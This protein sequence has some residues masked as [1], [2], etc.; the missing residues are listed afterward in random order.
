M[1]QGVSPEK[2]ESLWGALESN[3]VSRRPKHVNGD[4]RATLTVWPRE[5]LYIC[6]RAQ[7]VRTG[8]P[9][10]FRSFVELYIL[11]LAS[12]ARRV[13]LEALTW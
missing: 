11:S 1:E 3:G 13:R 7:V 4:K 9:A 10:F 2:G 6:A 5:R 8:C 12:P